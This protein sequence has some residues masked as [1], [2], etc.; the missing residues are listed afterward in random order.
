[1]DFRLANINDLSK[2]KAVVGNIS[3]DDLILREYG[4]EIEV[5]R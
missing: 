2:I 3:E 4:F 5:L 1:M